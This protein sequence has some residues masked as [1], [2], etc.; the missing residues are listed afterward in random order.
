MEDEELS[1]WLE[2]KKCQLETGRLPLVFCEAPL[3]LME[4]LSVARPQALTTQV[5]EIDENKNFVT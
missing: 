3:T 1:D 5:I 4:L 2:I